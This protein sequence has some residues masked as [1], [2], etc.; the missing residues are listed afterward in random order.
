MV[1]QLMSIE[2]ELETLKQTLE[3]AGYEA[4]SQMTEQQNSYWTIEY[5]AVIEC[6]F[7]IFMVA[8]QVRSIRSWFGRKKPH[9]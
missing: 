9:V 7:T 4:N 5:L 3:D 6:C 2:T 8:Y 1:V